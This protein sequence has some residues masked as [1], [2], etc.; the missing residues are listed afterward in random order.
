MN[1]YIRM[2]MA[3]PTTPSMKVGAVVKKK[4]PNMSVAVNVQPQSF[5]V[6]GDKF[7]HGKTVIDD[8]GIVKSDSK[9]DEALELK[10]EELEV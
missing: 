5:V 9:L 7:V 2:A 8:S 10:A 4:K 6:D 1:P 3:S